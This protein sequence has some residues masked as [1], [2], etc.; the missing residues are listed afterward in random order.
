MKLLLQEIAVIGATILVGGFI[1]L[2][3]AVAI[4]WRIFELPSRM[5]KKWNV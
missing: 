3:V 5:L 1:L 2:C 4:L